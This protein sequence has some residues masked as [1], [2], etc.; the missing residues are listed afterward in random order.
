LA[1]KVFGSLFALAG[2][3]LAVIFVGSGTAG[4]LPA[5]PWSSQLQLGSLAGSVWLLVGAGALYMLGITLAG[6]RGKDDDR[7][8]T[9]EVVILAT[10]AVG[11]G[12]AIAQILGARAMWP[13]SVLGALLVG[14]SAECV[15]GFA[16]CL[17][18]A[19]KGGARKLLFVPGVILELVLVV[20]HLLVL[21]LGAA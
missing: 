8:A 3:A 21:A 19:I 11:I 17:V 6:R 10:S 4:L 20:F 12:L 5:A 2:V 15:A 13:E 7:Y 1:A 16:L 9:A 14:S 18:V